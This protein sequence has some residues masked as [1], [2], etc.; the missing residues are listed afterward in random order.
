MWN[1]VRSAMDVGLQGQATRLLTLGQDYVANLAQD[2]KD[3]TLEEARTQAIAVGITAAIVLFGLFFV[4]IAVSIGL[5]ALYFAVAPVHGPF[6]G[7]AAAGGAA[8]VIAAAMFTIVAVRAGNAPKPKARP[9]LNAVK[10]QAKDAWQKTAV[11]AAARGGPTSTE[12]LALGKQT[13]DAAAG[14]VR[15][16][17]REAVL[18]TLAATV[19]VG[20]LIGRRR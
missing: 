15:D 2:Y 11:S 4:A 19:I 12:A 14:I 9:N 18:A 7:F 13:V 17:S 3:R 5:I 16:G 6:A 10:S 1:A 20:M 8:A